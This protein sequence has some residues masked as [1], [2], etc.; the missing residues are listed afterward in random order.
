MPRNHNN[1][2]TVYG[3]SDMLKQFF[4]SCM[5]IPA[6]YP[7][8]EWMA[9][10][11]FDAPCFCFHTLI[12]TPDF[13]LQ[14]GFG[15]EYD[16]FCSKGRVRET[17]DMTELQGW[18]WNILNWGTPFDIDN[19]SITMENISWGKDGRSAAIQF[20]TDYGPPSVWLLKTAKMYPHL[21]FHLQFER[22]ESH[23]PSAGDMLVKGSVAK[24]FTYRLN[25]C[26][27]FCQR[28]EG[29]LPFDPMKGCFDCEQAQSDICLRKNF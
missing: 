17:Q 26:T 24:E 2:L 21:L 20:L 1:R 23:D 13:V 10:P 11:Y 25:A 3:E 29:R 9:F 6:Q 19:H 28:E 15:E 4:Q 16:Y 18:Q 12:P 7:Q 27:A 5:G 8:P 14:N 22:L